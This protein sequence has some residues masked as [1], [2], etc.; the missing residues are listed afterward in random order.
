[1]KKTIVLM[2]VLFVFCA[3][4]AFALPGP[5][6][7]GTCGGELRCDC[8]EAVTS[9]VTLS[10]N[11]ECTTD[12]Y[13]LYA[14]GNDITINCNGHSITTPYGDLAGIIIPGPYGDVHVTDCNIQ[15]FDKGVY[16]TN[17]DGNH[18]EENTISGVNYGVYLLTSAYGEVTENDIIDTANSGIYLDGRGGASYNTISGNTINYSAQ[19]CSSSG[20]PSCGA[21]ELNYEDNCVIEDNHIYRSDNNGV[22]L[23]ESNHNQILDNTLVDINSWGIRLAAHNPNVGGDNTVNGNTLTGSEIRVATERNTI[24]NNVLDGQ[25]DS[26]NGIYLG[27]S[28]WIDTEGNTFDGNDI[29][30]YYK[31]VYAGGV[32]S[33]IMS[34]SQIHG[35]CEGI[36]L[37]SAG[38]SA[39]GDVVQNNDPDNLEF[40]NDMDRKTGIY[41]D[42]SSTLNFYGGTISN[43][44]DYG[45]FSILG[46]KVDWQ[47]DGSATCANNALYLGDY[48]SGDHSV[49]RDVDRENC[50]IW[51]A[52]A[53][54]KCGDVITEDVTLTNPI[55]CQGMYTYGLVAGANNITIN[56]DGQEVSGD[57]GSGSGI[58]VNGYGGVT[59][60]NCDIS[61]FSY[62]ID[63]WD[64]LPGVTMQNNHIHSNSYG[65]YSRENERTHVLENTFESNSIGVYFLA[66]AYGDIIANTITDG[67]I[68]VYLVEGVLPGSYNTVEGNTIDPWSSGTGIKINDD[69][70]QIIRNTV[71]CRWRSSGGYGIY[72]AGED[73]TFSGNDVS[74]CGKGFVADSVDNF[75]ISGDNY[76]DNNEGAFINGASGTIVDT[77]FSDNGGA[78]TGLSLNN[79][80]IELVNGNFINNGDWG[81]DAYGNGN[82]LHWALTD[83]V[84]CSNNDIQLSGWIVPFGG[85]LDHSDNC[86]VYVNGVLLGENQSGIYV[87]DIDTSGDNEYTFGNPDFG[88]EGEIH[89]T[90]G[91]TG[92][93]TVNFYSKPPEGGTKFKLEG[94]GIWVDVNISGDIVNGLDYW[95]LRIYYTDEQLRAAGVTTSSLKITWYNPATLKWETLDTTV[96]KAEHYVEARIN[97]FSLFGVGG[98]SGGGGGGGSG[99]GTTASYGGTTLTG[100]NTTVE[101]FI[102]ETCLSQDQTVYFYIQKLKQMMTMTNLDTNELRLNN[103][104]VTIAQNATE[105]YD[106]NNNGVPDTK[107]VG[108]RKLATKSCFTIYELNEGMYTKKEEV[109][110]E[111]EAAAKAAEEAAKA[112]AQPT[113]EAKAP[114][115]KEVPVAGTNW[116]TIL[117]WGVPVLVIVA[118]A[119][120]YMYFRPKSPSASYVPT[121]TYAPSAEVKATARH[122]KPKRH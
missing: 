35:N 63:V 103:N 9:N 76:H 83:D 17:S 7:V 36:R 26:W 58:F 86:D 65:V 77:D 116:K 96:N 108:S 27:E 18:I 1:M 113:A 105:Y 40:C 10:D 118:L 54:Y 51:P 91:S 19:D 78:E 120:L 87:E 33:F 75:T 48:P 45:I 79:S 31:G 95:I 57:G 21:I 114:E 107:I 70:N 29:S 14:Y 46:S 13:G 67:N 3:G 117:S 4:M 49:D 56:C 111:E 89:S 97:H 102:M 43:N 15:G 84:V 99:G 110:K 71:D 41:V 44:G 115:V 12:N 32:D 2:L 90:D 80:E 30:G 50:P 60:E 62:G 6:P 53:E 73:N 16:T 94:L 69:N 55:V 5:R 59:I 11:I 81:V 121:K 106:V 38:L 52:E 74:N 92:T 93:L 66:T 47:A 8:G 23:Y 37:E 109:K 100:S 39:Y 88:I 85:T 112:A 61:G 25:G 20:G 64:G 82:T 68:G 34:D 98:T 28:N 122:H 72:L 101:N 119:G 42:S 104:P 24:N 22:T